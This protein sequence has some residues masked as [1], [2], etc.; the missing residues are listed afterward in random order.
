MYKMSCEIPFTRTGADGLLK[1]PEAVG[2]MMDCCQFQEYQEKDFCEFLRSNKIAV[3]LSSIQIDIL[4]FPRFREKVDTAVKIY[5]YKTLYGLR[6]ITMRD[7]KGELCMIA[8]AT[9]AFFDL[10][11]L[12]ALKLDPAVFKLKFDEAEP[13]ECLPRKISIPAGEGTALPEFRVMPSALD[14][15]GHLTSA[16]Y[17]AI[18]SD[19]LPQDFSYNRTRIEYKKQAKNGDVIFPVLHLAAG[20]A[21]VDMRGSDGISHAVAEF[22][23]YPMSS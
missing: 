13:M 3:F 11:T 8:N 19:R 18:A 2:M 21:V 7:E 5:G 20:T 17:F 14:Y 23:T 15:N 9:G 10:K 16:V 6:R 4:R 22:S 12:R 1:L